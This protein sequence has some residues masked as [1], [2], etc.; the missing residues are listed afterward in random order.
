MSEKSFPKP[1]RPSGSAYRTA[2]VPL[3]EP[4]RVEPAK[5][6]VVTLA[7]PPEEEDLLPPKA[8]LSRDEINALLAVNETNTMTGWGR[9]I[10]RFKVAAIPMGVISS[11]GHFVFGWTAIIATLAVGILWALK[12]M[13]EQDRAGWSAASSDLE[14]RDRDEPDRKKG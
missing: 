12:P 5:R 4:E 7:D 9:S 11:L 2:S 1:R 8:N 3:V 14:D 13:T 6:T 10:E